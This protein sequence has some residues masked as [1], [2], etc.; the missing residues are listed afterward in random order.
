MDYTLSDKNDSQKKQYESIIEQNNKKYFKLAEEI[1]NIKAG[2]E[3]TAQNRQFAILELQ[4]QQEEIER[5]QTQN[6]TKT[7]NFEGR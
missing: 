2:K 7:N 4:I 3:G 5:E 1:K 6:Q